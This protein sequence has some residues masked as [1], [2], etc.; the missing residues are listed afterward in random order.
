MTSHEY[1]NPM[2]YGEIGPLIRQYAIPSIISGLV[3]ALYNIVD[4]I[5]IGQGVGILGNAATNVAFPFTNMA[6][7]LGLLVGVGASASY[8]LNLGRNKKDLAGNYIFQGLSLL[9]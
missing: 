2:G 4:Q 7:A 8:S 5:F 9:F 3:G 1:R 6:L